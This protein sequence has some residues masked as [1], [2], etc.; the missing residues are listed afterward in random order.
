MT[1]DEL[2]VNYGLVVTSPPYKSNP[3]DG[4]HFYGV[5]KNCFY[6][7]AQVLIPGAY[8]CFL[9]GKSVIRGELIDNASI[10]KRAAV[11]N[12]FVPVATI[13]RN[14]PV[15]RK[16][17]NPNHASFKSDRESLVIVQVKG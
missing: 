12:G 17:F 1:P 11:D 2:G 7:L 13:P 8:A 16:S 14:I 10:V 4:E 15:T 6:L 3:H 5:M 9:I